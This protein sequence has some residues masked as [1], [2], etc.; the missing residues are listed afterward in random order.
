M[1]THI[2]DGFYDVTHA[3]KCFHLVSEHNASAG[4]YA[5]VIYSISVN[6]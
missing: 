4:S 6:I 5:A 1:S 2:E 3:E